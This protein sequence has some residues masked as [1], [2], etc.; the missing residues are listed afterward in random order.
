LPRDLAAL[1]A[2]IRRCTRCELHESRTVAVP[3]EGA[4]G[5]RIALVGEAPGWSEDRAGRPFVG[6]AGRI[7]DEALRKAGIVRELTFITN[8]VKC[9]P[10]GN[11]RP[12]PSE[13]AACRP[14]LEAQLAAVRPRVV[15]ALGAS[16]VHDL[17]GAEEKFASIRGRW[18]TRGGRR[19][20]A[21]YHPAAVLYNRALLPTLIRD[22]ARARTASGF[23]R[24][25]RVAGKPR[26]D[27]RTLPTTSAGCVVLDDRGRVFLLRRSDEG[28]WCFPKG[29]IERGET[30]REAALRE[31]REE[32]GLTV[33]IGPK[34]LEIRYSLYWPP[35]DVNY[36]KRVVYFA[37]RRRGGKVRLEPG[38]DAYR[39]TEAATAAKV[40]PYANDRRVLRAAL[41]VAQTGRPK[42]RRISS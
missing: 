6:A 24:P 18:V 20:L 14:Y 26:K 32:C 12:S 25:R 16:A 8:A 10:P 13:M 40:L 15:V 29:G 37:A 1:A 34:A 3:G 21:T 41:A 2:R 5:S 19:I 35:D 23:V 30:T 4:P 31:V 11:R 42:K 38:F 17:L 9:R 27:R 36:N 39:W 22:L 28:T 33:D 7:L